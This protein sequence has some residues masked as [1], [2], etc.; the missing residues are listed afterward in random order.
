MR[1]SSLTLRKLP[2]ASLSDVLLIRNVIMLF[3]IISH[4]LRIPEF[5][6]CITIVLYSLKGRK[7]YS[8]KSKGENSEQVD[9][10]QQGI[11]VLYL[12]QSHSR[13]RKPQA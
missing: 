9:D 7:H 12:R 5:R 11:K 8:L 2:G 13:P 1:T 4:F 3:Q 10:L 6:N